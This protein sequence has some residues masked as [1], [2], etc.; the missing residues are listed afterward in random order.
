VDTDHQVIDVWGYH[1]TCASAADSILRNGFKLSQNEYDWLGDG[2][3]FFQDAP[4]RAWEWAQHRWP[5]EPAVLKSR[6]RLEDCMDLLDSGWS[7]LLAD[8]YDQFLKRMN[9]AGLSVPRQTMGAHRLDRYVINFAVGMLGEAG[10]Q[11]RAVRGA[12]LEGAPV[13]PNSFLFDRA[14]VQIAIRD[15]DLIMF[16]ERAR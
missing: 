8:A 10:I 11:I 7:S 3:Y 9:R 13:F 1:G 14:H 5:S 4:E 15:V 16:S 6:L 2:I 12:F